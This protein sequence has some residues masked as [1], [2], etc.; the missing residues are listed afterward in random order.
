MD[1]GKVAGVTCFDLN[2]SELLAKYE[3]SRPE[4]LV[5]CSSFHGGHMQQH[6]AYTCRAYF[7]GACSGNRLPANIW[8]PL[9]YEEARSSTY[10]PFIT[11]TINLDYAVAHIDYNREKFEALKK[12]YGKGVNIYDPGYLG[13][14][15]ITSEMDG[16]SA[17]DMIR[18]FE[19]ELLDDYMARAAAA[20]YIDGRIEK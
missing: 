8:N 13:S 2:F 15:L 10:L 9:G 14:V 6:W 20:R 3:K 12:K 1:F 5:F 18:E 4:L 11:H 19:I 7:V 17:T 16:I